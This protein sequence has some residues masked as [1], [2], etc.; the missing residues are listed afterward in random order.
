MTHFYLNPDRMG[1]FLP[2]IATR[3]EKNA[4]H[5]GC[6]DYETF[7]EYM[8][9]KGRAALPVEVTPGGVAII[10]VMG[11]LVSAQIPDWFWYGDITY[12]QVTAALDEA[13]KNNA[14]QDIVL[15]FNSPG[16][17]VTGCGEAADLINR[18]ASVKP[19]TAHCQMAD[20]AAYWMASACS[21][22]I[23]DAA[24]GEVGSIG[25]I[26]THFDYSKMLEEWGIKATHIYAGAHKADG[27]PYGPLSE[28]AQARWQAE[29]DFL[30]SQFVKSVA[31]MRGLAPDGVAATEALTYCGDDAIGAGLADSVMFYHEMLERLEAPAPLQP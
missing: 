5:A 19:V 17:T 22:I 18:A 10:N 23:L 1:L 25:V 26:A 7:A 16:G 31:E 29:M 12:E 6:D 27:S 3:Y 20:S 11:A 15:R 4:A 2:A 8:S 24:S 28:K 21:H 13:V 14:V 30:R 9:R